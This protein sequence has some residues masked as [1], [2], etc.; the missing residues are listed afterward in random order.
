MLHHYIVFDPREEC[1][2]NK[3][4]YEKIKDD[5]EDWELGDLYRVNDPAIGVLDSLELF[6]DDYMTDG[7]Q[8]PAAQEREPL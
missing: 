5:L 8:Q 6:S 1:L 2:V 3:L 4:D 7:R